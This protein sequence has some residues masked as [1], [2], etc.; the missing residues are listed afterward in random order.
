MKIV[1]I[2]QLCRKTKKGEK[3]SDLKH[4]TFVNDWKSLVF[5]IK[6]KFTYNKISKIDNNKFEE[7]FNRGLS[8]YIIAKKLNMS[9]SGIYSHRI[10]Y[11]YLREKNLRLNDSIKL[12]DFQKQVLIGTMLGDASFRL[13]DGCVSPRVSCAHGIKQKE[14]CEYKTEIFKNLGAK[15]KYHKRNVIDKR[16]GIY[17]ED[18]TMYI[19]ANP[20]FLYYYKEFYPENKKTIPINLLNQFTEVSLAF[21]FMDDGSKTK[22]GYKI[23][24]NCFT[25]CSIETFIK[26]LNEKWDIEAS[27]H[28]DKG[29]Y[30]K[31]NSKKIFKKL[32]SPY[33]CECMKYKLWIINYSLSTLWIWENLEIGNP[34]PSI[35]EIL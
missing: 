18:Y 17:Y 23:A 25:L 2:L 30:I 22:N 8:D 7:L 31:S 34:Y 16:T 29:I 35:I 4:F 3:L 11:N 5:K 1:W 19:P 33:I 28:K 6:S 14:Y 24:T 27:I 20:E 15:C 10:R 12:T 32:I 9:P 13:S 26:F 21:M